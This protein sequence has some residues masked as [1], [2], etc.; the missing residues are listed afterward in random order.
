MRRMQASSLGVLAA[1]IVACTSGGSKPTPSEPA[2]RSDH[3]DHGGV[4]IEVFSWWSRIGE[5][6]ALGA[7]TTEH[8]L[9]FPEDFIVNATT[10]LSGL[11]RKTLRV[12]MDHGEPPDTFQ[13]NI[14][15][16]LMRWVVVNGID[17]RLS[18]LMPLDVV[19]PDVAEW[20]QHIPA[21]L[22]RELSYRGRLYAVP[23]T[24]HRLNEIFYNR[25]VFRTYGLE[26]PRTVRRPRGDCTQAVRLLG[27]ADR[28]R[29]SRTVDP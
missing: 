29:E 17:D 4:P 3:Y 22:L 13:A 1:A 9:H 14:G 19:M 15:Q 21:I 10:E 20:R 27:R 8:Q 23:A 28:P 11:A 18:K 25:N 7:L 12:R 5:S 24:V 26:E 6:D 2:G 16:D